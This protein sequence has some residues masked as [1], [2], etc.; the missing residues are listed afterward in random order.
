M[1]LFWLDLFSFPFGFPLEPGAG[2]RIYLCFLFKQGLGLFHSLVYKYGVD[3]LLLLCSV[4]TTKFQNKS[5]LS[6]YL[7]D[8]RPVRHN[9]PITM[10][11]IALDVLLLPTASGEKG[12]PLP[13]PEPGMVNPFFPFLN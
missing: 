4:H 11:T 8:R 7:V 13:F 5:K 9:P 1:C 2:N 3:S 6:S 12:L 10:A